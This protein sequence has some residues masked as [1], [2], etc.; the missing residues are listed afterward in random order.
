[1]CSARCSAGICTRGVPLS[2]MPLLGVKR[3]HAC[4]PMAWPRGVG[5]LSYQLTLYLPSKHERHVPNS[6]ADGSST[7]FTVAYPVVVAG[8]TG[9]WWDAAQ[10][11]RKWVLCG[12]RIFN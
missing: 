3:C 5:R 1:V 2:F 10:I 11:Y 6:F 7:D 8:F 9:G 12:D 4:D